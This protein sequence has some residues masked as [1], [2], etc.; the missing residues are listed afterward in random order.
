[1]ARMP[2]KKEHT[3]EARSNQTNAV[4]LSHHIRERAQN[5]GPCCQQS[6][7]TSA[8]ALAKKIGQGIQVHGPKVRGNE[9][10][11]QTKTTRPS[12]HVSQSTRL[13]ARAREALQIKRTRQTDE[14]GGTHPVG[15]CGHAVVKS[16]DASACHVIL[17]CI[18]GSARNTNERINHDGREQEGGADQVP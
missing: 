8:K 4:N 9:Q 17:F 1:M 7:P 13:T 18:G 14:G 3:G 2:P 12:H 5:S 6:W 11:H 10:R 16:R 15:G